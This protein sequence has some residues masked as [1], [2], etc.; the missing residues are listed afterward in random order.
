MKARA[1]LH[2]TVSRDS[3][4]DWSLLTGPRRDS[5][6]HNEATHALL[7][8]ELV[9]KTMRNELE[10]SSKRPWCSDTPFRK[11]IDIV[12]FIKNI[13]ADVFAIVNSKSTCRINNRWW[14]SG[15]P[16]LTSLNIRALSSFEWRKVVEEPSLTWYN[17]YRKNHN[18]Y[19]IEWEING[20]NK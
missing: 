19:L 3:Q 18:S 17:N 20:R 7:P 12:P 8:H 6:F 14:L 13:P 15:V 10:T 9:R 2:W 1:K 5:C 4:M 16:N 11:Y